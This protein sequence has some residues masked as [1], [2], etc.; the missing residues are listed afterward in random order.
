MSAI[1]QG[2]T[3]AALSFEAAYEQLEGVLSRLQMGNLSL[4]DSLA[5]FEEGMA[6]AAHCQALLDAAELR[7]EQL[8][9][10]AP[11]DDTDDEPPF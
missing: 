6:L 10:A 4:D 9:R 5:A 2:D 8:E 3:L 1:E 11:A 7:V